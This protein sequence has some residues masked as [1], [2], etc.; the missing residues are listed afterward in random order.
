MDACRL[1]HGQPGAAASAHQSCLLARKRVGR[2]ELVGTKPDVHAHREAWPLEE[3]SG[4]R[5]QN[6]C[7]LVL[8]RGAGSRGWGVSWILRSTRVLGGGQGLPHSSFLAGT[9]VRA[10]TMGTRARQPR[11]RAHRGR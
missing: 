2:R 9:R 11:K 8:G 7:R 5:I 10:M 1:S 6:R 4:R 3:R